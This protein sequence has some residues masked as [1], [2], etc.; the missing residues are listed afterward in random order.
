MTQNFHNS[1]EVRL[2]FP[3]AS[4]ST[5]GFYFHSLFTPDLLPFHR[6]A[7]FSVLRRLRVLIHTD[8][9]DE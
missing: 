9:A 2:R 7:M 8:E 1:H 4:V 3:V 6:H 5:S